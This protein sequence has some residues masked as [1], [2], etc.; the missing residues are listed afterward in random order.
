MDTTPTY[1]GEVSILHALRIL[2]EWMGTIDQKLLQNIN[3]HAGAAG[4]C[5][6]I[7]S[8]MGGKICSLESP[9]ASGII[10]ELQDLPNWNGVN[11]ALNPFYL[12]D[13]LEAEEH[14]LRIKLHASLAEFFR[15]VVV[16]QQGRKWKSTLPWIPLTTRELKAAVKETFERDEGIILS[17][18]AEEGSVSASIIS[19]LELTRSIV[20]EALAVLGDSRET[21]Q[22]LLDIL[23]ATRYRTIYEGQLH[24]TVCPKQR[25]SS[26]D[27]FWHM[28]ECYHLGDMVARGPESVPFLTH[29]ARTTM[30]PKGRAT[31][32]HQELN[33]KES[34]LRDSAFILARV[35]AYQRVVPSSQ[36]HLAGI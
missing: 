27:D 9:A 7:E 21:Q 15:G 34:R 36:M 29:M 22:N 5:R 4:A 23:G 8:W 16:P 11:I 18:L 3:L 24:Y 35:E 30:K 28:I 6:Q 25:C 20:K 31:I 13:E 10:Q 2:K 12:P 14:N 32:P 26:R 1:I 17:M 19:A 33:T